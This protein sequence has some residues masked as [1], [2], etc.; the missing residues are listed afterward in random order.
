[1]HFTKM[2]GAGND[3]IV[4]DNKALK[5]PLDRLPGMAR[6][7]CTRRISIGG[8]ALMAADFPEQGGDFRMR[9]Y[10]P[11]G[12]VAEM[13]GNGARCIAR[14]AYERGFARAHM[15]I[16]TVA[17]PVQAWR[18][19]RR[20]YKIKLNNPG[21]LELHRP[22]EAR[23]RIWDCAYVELGTPGIPHAVVHYPGLV[24]AVE[25]ELRALGRTLRFHSAFPKG[26]NV[27]FYDVVSG[28]NVV[29][30]T[31]ERGVEDFTLACG[32]GSGST[33]AVLTLLGK[34]PGPTVHLSVPGGDL[35]IEV[36]QTQARITGLYLVGDTNIVAEGEIM[37][38]DL[39]L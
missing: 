25:D 7:L 39:V 10:N 5:L 12:T 9:F 8:D 17:G 4:I 15:T 37:D 19:D 30:K 14:Y 3:F 34:L 13:C 36:E 23:G 24:D 16:E 31:Y 32:T 18:Q 35:W 33:A 28:G 11:D 21:T 22:V 6:R 20:R 27:N 38:E 26:A 2:Q 1:M 29:E